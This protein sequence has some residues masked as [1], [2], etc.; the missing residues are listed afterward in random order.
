MKS[1]WKILLTAM[2]EYVAEGDVEFSNVCTLLKVSC[3]LVTALL[4]Y[5]N[6]IHAHDIS[7]SI[8]QDLFALLSL[9]GVYVVGRSFLQY[10]VL[11]NLLV[12]VLSLLSFRQKNL[13]KMLTC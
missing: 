7:C 10:I 1:N 5:L 6:I 4:G 2:V 8:Y 12:T 9:W 11:T 3:I 13:E